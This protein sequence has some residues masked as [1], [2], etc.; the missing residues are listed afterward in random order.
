M[1]PEIKELMERVVRKMNDDENLVTEYRSWKEEERLINEAI[2]NEVREKSINEGI[3]QTKKEMVLNMHN[4]N[5]TLDII[6]E[7]ANLTIEEVKKIIE[8]NN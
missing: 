6:A 4:K 3:A 8:D 1:K 5:I 7:C 2:I